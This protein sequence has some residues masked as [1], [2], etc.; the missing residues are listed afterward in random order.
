MTAMPWFGSDRRKQYAA[1]PWRA[2]ASGVELLLVTSRRTRRWIIPKGWPMKGRTGPEAA[3]QEAWEEGGVRGVI[4]GTPLGIFGYVKHYADAPDRTCSVKVFA[5]AVAEV[6]DVWPEMA[7]RERRWMT[8]AD[9]AAAVDEP[10]LKALIL[11]FSPP[12]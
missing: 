1:L 3:A 12:D 8:P 4:A 10:E 11:G 6:D 9:A 7:Q 2:G 5:L